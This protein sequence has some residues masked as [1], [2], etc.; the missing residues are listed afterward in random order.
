L[1]EALHV[2][3]GATGDVVREALRLFGIG[4]SQLDEGKNAC[5]AAGCKAGA[6]NGV[7]AAG[8]L[9]HKA[10]VLRRMTRWSAM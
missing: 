9:D 6:V 8:R 2:A 1:V 4:C 5:L 3:D 7:V 10:S